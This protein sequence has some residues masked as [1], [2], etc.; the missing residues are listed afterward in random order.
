MTKFFQTKLLFVLILSGFFL[1]ASPQASFAQRNVTLYSVSPASAP[2]GAMVVI[3]GSNLFGCAPGATT[4]DRRCNVQFHDINLRRSTESGTETSN[5]TVQ[6]VVAAG[7]CP[8]TTTIKV[9]ELTDFSNAIPFTIL[10]Q[11]AVP[12]NCRVITS[13]SPTSGT[14]G[15]AV[16]INGRLLHTNVQLYDS[17]LRKTDVTGIMNGTAT[18]VTFAMP[19]GLTPGTYSVRVGPSVS[20]VSNGLPFNFIGDTTA[21]FI[22]NIR[23]NNI[24]TSGATVTWDTNEPADGQV[25]ICP[26]L[27][28]CTTNTPLISAL[29]TSHVVNLSGLT[30]NARYY[31]WIKSRDARSNLA[32]GGPM[33]F[34]TLAA[35]TPTPIPPPT[36]VLPVI[37]NAQVTNITR[38]SATVTWTTDRPANSQVIFCTTIIFC[39]GTMVSDSNMTTNHSLNTSTLK[40]NRKYYAT[41]TS[42]DVSG[43]RSVS[44]RI[45]FAT[46]PG[47]S[48]S[49]VSASATSSSATVNWSTNYPANSR[50]SVCRIPVF[51]YSDIAV[52]SPDYVLSHSLTVPGLTSDA[53]YYYTLTSVDEL[54]YPVYYRGSIR[55][56]P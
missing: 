36:V 35:I 14:F 50:L 56:S 28:R 25:E 34:R 22:S 27:T 45:I 21:P 23:I 15:T 4:G 47:L 24:T 53:R 18:Q 54:G 20:D 2:V 17:S 40:P 42:T 43:I 16:T 13:I 48:I 51:C 32:T 7:L 9:G 31:L 41:I 38:N 26:S 1:L 6:A 44:V 11:G 52:S 55:I 49:G 39:W 33:S 12:A 46:L 19:N 30:P 29:T 10:D 37:S 5:T 3:T 8:G